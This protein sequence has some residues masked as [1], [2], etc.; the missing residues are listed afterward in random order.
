M[1]PEARRLLEGL[2]IGRTP[3]D[4]IQGFAE[5]FG[6][7]QIVRILG[8]PEEADAAFRRWWLPGDLPRQPN[9]LVLPAAGIADFARE[10]KG[11]VADLLT[12][13]EKL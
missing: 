1:V 6:L 11:S 12:F 8:L 4:F 2:A 7:S 10:H 3:V 9:E 5:P 13:I